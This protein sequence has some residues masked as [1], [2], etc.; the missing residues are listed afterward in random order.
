[1]KQKFYAINKGIE[2]QCGFDID[3]LKLSTAVQE[4][5]D[6]LAALPMTLWHRIA[7]KN[8]T[9]VVGEYLVAAIAATTNAIVNPIEKGY[10]D[11]LPKTAISATEKQ[12]RNYPTGLEIK[13]TCGTLSKKCSLEVGKPR[14]PHLKGLTWQAHHREVNQLLSFVWDFCEITENQISPCIT[15]IFYSANLNESDWGVISGTTGRNTKVSGMVKSGKSK[16]A[17]GL[18]C[19]INDEECKSRY[20]KILPNLALPID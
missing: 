4:C 8:S 1:M 11:L 2:F 9:A 12:L 13:G 17:E 10:P 14:L 18:V 7:L 6:G 3:S 15:A 16:M 5:N 20:K 19:V